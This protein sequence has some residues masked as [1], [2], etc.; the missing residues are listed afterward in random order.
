MFGL[1]SN[2]LRCLI[3]QS[4][5]DLEIVIISN[6]NDGFM[7]DKIRVLCSNSSRIK[8]FELKNIVGAQI[9]M[10]FGFTVSSGEFVSFHDQDD[11]SSQDRFKKLLLSMDDDIIGSNINIIHGENIRVKGFDQD[12]VINKFIDR[13]LIKSPA[14]FGSLIMKRELFLEMG[15]FEYNWTADSLFCIKVNL[16]RYFGF[17]KKLKMIKEPLFSWIRHQ[18]SNTS[19]KRGLVEKDALD[20]RNKILQNHQSIL[21]SKYSELKGFLGITDNFKKCIGIEFA[22]II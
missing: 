12:A 20:S 11:I 6:G 17:G 19:G 15:G 21:S 8:L 13:K 3:G 1:F 5:E 7:N 9:S 2:T 4:F 18:S 22:R 10:N 16:L 14:H